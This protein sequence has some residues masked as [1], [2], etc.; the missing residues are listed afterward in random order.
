[1]KFTPKKIIAEEELQ[2]PSFSR[3]RTYDV[4]DIMEL[5][6]N[7]FILSPENLPKIKKLG[8]KYDIL[9]TKPDAILDDI[10]QNSFLPTWS[11]DEE[12]DAEELES[13]LKNFAKDMEFTQDE[14]N[15][16]CEEI[17]HTKNPTSARIE[18]F[19]DV[20]QSDISTLENLRSELSTNMASV[21]IGK[22]INELKKLEYSGNK[23]ETWDYNKYATNKSKYTLLGGS[24]EDYE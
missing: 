7:S 8:S 5:I 6:N 1:M 15:E 9:Y 20:L 12:I 24:D 10:C 14:L 3:D 18:E 2:V 21:G 11:G 17:K 4:N 23:Y 13:K 16:L 19:N 22:L